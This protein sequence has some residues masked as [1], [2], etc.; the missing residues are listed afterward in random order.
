MLFEGFSNNLKG[1]MPTQKVILVAFPDD[2]SVNLLL[3][4]HKNNTRVVVT[5]EKVGLWK[6]VLRKLKL[7]REVEL[8]ELGEGFFSTNEPVL[9]VDTY[10]YRGEKK[11][12]NQKK[13]IYA[14]IKH[15]FGNHKIFF[16]GSLENYSFNEAHVFT[17]SMD[18]SFI[19][20]AQVYKSKNKSPYRLMTVFSSI[21]EKLKTGKTV[22]LK[23]S[24]APIY[25]MSTIT[26]A[27][28]IVSLVT[29]QHKTA[30]RVFGLAEEVSTLGNFLVRVMG[31]T[32]NLKIIYSHQG[33]ECGNVFIPDQ[34]KMVFI[35]G[36]PSV[37][38]KSKVMTKEKKVR[39]NYLLPL[40]SLVRPAKKAIVWLFVLSVFLSTPLI[41]FFGAG[42]AL[43][44]MNTRV[45][46]YLFSFSA[47]TFNLYAEV[48]SDERFVS[49]ATLSASLSNLSE[50]MIKLRGLSVKASNLGDVVL[51]KNKDISFTTALADL[52][53][54]FNY[55]YRD[56]QFLLNDL[57]SLSSTNLDY[58]TKN[59]SSFGGV[60]DSLG[61]VLGEND[62]KR[63]LVM[64]QNNT[65]L[66]PTGG[67]MGSFA[68]LTFQK[69]ILV[70]V[71][72]HD[73]YDADGQ[74]KGH[75]EPPMP[76][77]KYLG[78]ANWFM[79]D[80]NWD[81]DFATT[82]QRI[83][84]FLQKEME[85]E[86]DGVWGI[87][88]SVIQS[89]VA[90]LGEVKVPDYD[91]YISA[92]N[93]YEVV[94]YETEKDFFP[95]S[96]RKANFLSA[97]T[98][99]ILR[100]L[101]E[102]KIQKPD[103]L[104]SLFLTSVQNKHLQVY[105]TNPQDQKAWEPLELSWK[106]DN[107]VYTQS[108]IEANLG[109]NKA[110]NYLKRNI[111]VELYFDN[112]KILGK[113]SVLFENIAPPILGYK[114][115]NKNYV[116]LFVPN[117]TEIESIR[118]VK[119][120]EESQVT[121]EPENFGTY[122]SE[123]LLVEIPN[124]GNALVEFQWQAETNLKEFRLAKQYGLL[125]GTPVTIAVNRPLTVNTPL[126]YNCTLNSDCVFTFNWK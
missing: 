74:L 30:G 61:S 90:A 75:V 34:D 123:G 102:E 28:Y 13:N 73:V 95:G 53:Q 6:S 101:T 44:Q 62:E 11:H 125:D 55:Y 10:F 70:E 14:G 40:K 108:L 58:L 93:F 64:L 35:G 116:R 33:L 120:G 54:D 72:I 16:I 31:K 96:T 99:E 122:H 17:S 106:F 52:K 19:L 113:T 114:G 32:R 87:D 109:V 25:P 83:M 104:A 24:D 124:S 60:I 71:K 81:P 29:N 49:L 63:Y 46:S 41:I 7:H 26:V 22:Y 112:D 67:F 9:V 115:M 100:R 91:K 117:N 27:A 126:V 23:F 76:I 37:L 78:E 97:L 88:V 1:Y 59:L 94:Q 48:T 45:A 43:A 92:D 36:V 47:K 98:Q 3:S 57:S 89:L 42:L 119:R 39:K 21:V 2:L 110:S 69:G 66:R 68:L 4:L 103:M 50:D 38:L 56:I 105:F 80:A 51:G 107:S 86:V 121:G 8:F 82:A 12:L 79:R 111:K 65:E 15:R 5:S 77:A 20:L 84:W 118:V 18:I 85:M